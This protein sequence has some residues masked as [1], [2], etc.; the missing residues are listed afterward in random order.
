VPA[1]K[2]AAR[3]RL[4][5]LEFVASFVCFSP[6]FSMQPLNQSHLAQEHRGKWVALK[7]DRRTVVASGKSAKSVL[8]AAKKKGFP[9]PIVTRLPNNPAHFIGANLPI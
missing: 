9:Q 3:N 8:G 2:K 4:L 6:S 5:F 1:F 7:S